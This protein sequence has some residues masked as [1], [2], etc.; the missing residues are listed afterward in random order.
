MEEYVYVVRAEIPYEESNLLAVFA[1]EAVA[2]DYAE[3]AL[4]HSYESY[5][6]VVRAPLKHELQPI[7]KSLNPEGFLSPDP[8]IEEVYSVDKPPLPRPAWRLVRE[9]AEDER[10]ANTK[11]AGSEWERDEQ[12][13]YVNR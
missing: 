10:P 12:G 11:L 9:A 1:D 2:K 4:K 8:E 7:D 6:T 3:Q 13:R 5:I